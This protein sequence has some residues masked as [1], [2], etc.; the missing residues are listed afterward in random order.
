MKKRF[1]MLISLSAIT[2]FAAPIGLAADTTK[3]P[4]AE[5]ATGEQIK[6]QV[7]SSG[8]SDATAGSSA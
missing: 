6:W 7:I 1:I 2:L 8:G 3:A 4:P 5:P